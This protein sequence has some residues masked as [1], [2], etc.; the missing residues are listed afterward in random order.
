M[1]LHFEQES[2]SD[3]GEEGVVIVVYDGDTLKVRFDDGSEKRV[4]LIGIDA[5]ETDDSREEARYR[6]HLAKRFVFYHLYRQ[7]VR[8]SYDW[9][10]EDKYGRILAYIWI[11]EGLFNEFILEE[12]FASV[13]LKYPFREDYRKRLMQAQKK[14]RRMEIGLW[15]RDPFPCLSVKQVKQNIGQ[16]S[17]VEFFCSQAKKEGKFIFF[18]SAKSEFSALVP[19]EAWHLFP[20]Y[21]SFQGMNLAVS[22]FLEEYKDKPQIMIFFPNQL[23]KTE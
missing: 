20:Q 13:F 17:C 9:E 18:H 10:L 3:D 5:P 21:K 11:D 1:F 7:R 23:K 19:Q 14:A 16:L 15:K 2:I 4:R 22:G 12:G 6:A 8:L